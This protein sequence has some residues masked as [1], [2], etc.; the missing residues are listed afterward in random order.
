[1]PEKLP[2]QVPMREIASREAVKCWD[3]VTLGYSREEAIAEARRVVQLDFTA[4]IARCPFE[5]DIPRFIRQVA[6]GDFDAALAT[7]R[8]AHPFA[9]TFGRHCHKYCEYPFTGERR[10]AT[11]DPTRLAPVISGLERAAGDFG[12]RDPSDFRPGS[13]TGRRVAIVGSGSAG[14][15]CAW[16]LRR[17]GHAVDIYERDV[18]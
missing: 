6:E 3:E 1:M 2:P 14:L 11:A 9:G 16:E 8:E 4:S 12:H 18:V 10:L 17:M 15:M 5:I 7:I 13:D